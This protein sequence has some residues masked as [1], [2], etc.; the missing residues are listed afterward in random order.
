M[1]NQEVIKV[2]FLILTIVLGLSLISAQGTFIEGFIEFIFG[3]KTPTGQITGG[4]CVDTDGYNNFD[5]FGW[6]EEE[7]YIYQD[8]CVDMDLDG[9]FET[10]YDYYCEGEAPPTLMV[11]LPLTGKATTGLVTGGGNGGGT[12]DPDVPNGN[13]ACPPPPPST[14]INC[15]TERGVPCLDN[16]GVCGCNPGTDTQTCVNNPD[17][18]I[19]TPGTQVCNANGDGWEQCLGSVE[20]DPAIEECAANPD[21]FI[22]GWV[23]VPIGGPA[24]CNTGDTQPCTIPGNQGICQYGFET[25]VGGVWGP[26]DT[27]EPGEYPEICNGLDDDCDG[28]IDEDPNMCPPDKYV[29][30]DIVCLRNQPVMIKMVMVME[31]LEVVIVQVALKQTAM[32]TLTNVVQVVIQELQKFVMEKIMIVMD[33]QMKYLVVLRVKPNHVELMLGCVKKELRHVV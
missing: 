23:C 25:C 33:Q 24:P 4:D 9:T 26:C 27:S 3:G 13:G 30:E 2:F 15:I 17:W 1:K 14:S 11:S 5:E 21:P 20:C 29:K 31:I 28:E 18:D 19:C 12:C 8:F 10:A 32:M 16:T 22:I 6:V 7:G